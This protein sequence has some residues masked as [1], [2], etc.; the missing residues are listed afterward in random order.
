MHLYRECSFQRHSSRAGPTAPAAVVQNRR[1]GQ[2]HSG[3]GPRALC[4]REG[5]CGR[6]SYRAIFHGDFMVPLF[7]LNRYG[8]FMACLLHF[9][10]RIFKKCLMG[11]QWILMLID[12]E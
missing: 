7:D 3:L 2:G 1:G 12:G 6:E 4:G 8:M 11:F 10:N 5:T 9:L